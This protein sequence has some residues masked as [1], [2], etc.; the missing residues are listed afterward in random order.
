MV[1]I[2]G[3]NYLKAEYFVLGRRPLRLTAI[4]ALDFGEHPCSEECAHFSKMCTFS[5][6]ENTSKM[7]TFSKILTRLVT[8]SFTWDDGHQNVNIQ[9]SIFEYELENVVLAMSG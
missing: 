3:S 6:S 8:D 4:I 9:R 1:E 2:E 7:C 5:D